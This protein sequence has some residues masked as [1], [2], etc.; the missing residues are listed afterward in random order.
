MTFQ[1]GVS[2][3]PKGRPKKGFAIADILDTVGDEPS[4]FIYVDP[5]TGEERKAT[6]R[7][8]M[9]LNTYDLAIKGDSSARNFIAERTEG[10]VTTPIEFEGSVSLVEVAAALTEGYKERE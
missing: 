7:E 6:K 9:L 1:P 2:G 10:K 4:T 3:N 8:V 5:D